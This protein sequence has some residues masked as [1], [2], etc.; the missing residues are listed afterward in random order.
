MR[1]TWSCEKCDKTAKKLESLIMV[2]G[3]RVDSLE[4][5]AEKSEEMAKAN[6]EQV[7]ILKEK[8]VNMEKNEKDAGATACTTVFNEIKDRENRK[9]NVVVH[10]MAE[11]GRR[12]KEGREREAANLGELQKVLDS[13][14]AEVDLKAVVRWSRRLGERKDN[15]DMARIKTR[16]LSKTFGYIGS[17]GSWLHI[18][19]FVQN[20]KISSN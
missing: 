14:Q 15:V 5:R 19:N 10:N 20:T 13:I 17:V 4:E 12:I 2:L 9:D 11:P 7:V 8:I 6:T 16:F 1:V 18:P 3:R